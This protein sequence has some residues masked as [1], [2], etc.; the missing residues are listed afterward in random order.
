MIPQ[1]GVSKLLMVHVGARS[2][3]SG[4]AFLAGA[5]RGLDR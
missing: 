1:R 5:P 2:W 3:G 4:T